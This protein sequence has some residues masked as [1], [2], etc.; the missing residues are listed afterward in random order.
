MNTCM[1]LNKKSDLVIERDGGSNP[2][3]VLGCKL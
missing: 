2:M 3:L 1:M